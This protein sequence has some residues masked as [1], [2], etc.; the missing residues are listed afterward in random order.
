MPKHL[1]AA[2]TP[3]RRRNVLVCT[4]THSVHG[5]VGTDLPRR[6]AADLL[7]PCPRAARAA[8][9]VEKQMR[10]CASHHRHHGVICPRFHLPSSRTTKTTHQLENPHVEKGQRHKA[11]FL[12]LGK[13]TP[14]WH[15]TKITSFLQVERAKLSSGFLEI[16]RE[17]QQQSS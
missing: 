11:A 3:A 13:V 2:V 7:P 8:K 15:R 5:G 14:G 16:L 10:A 17:K 12:L 9:W 6:K 4:E 1:A